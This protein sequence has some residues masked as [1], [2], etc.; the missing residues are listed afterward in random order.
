VAAARSARYS[1][2]TTRDEEDDAAA[3]EAKRVKAMESTLALQERMI[4]TLENDNKRLVADNKKLRDAVKAAANSSGRFDP[5]PAAASTTPDPV[6]PKIKAGIAG[7][8]DDRAAVSPWHVEPG[9]HQ[10]MVPKAVMDAEI[11]RRTRE[12]D[13]E[14][15]DMARKVAWYVDHQEFNRA[16]ET[17]IAEQQATIH[18]LRAKLMEMELIVGRPAGGPSKTDKDRQIRLLQ[19]RVVELEEAHRS[20]QGAHSLT[21]LI[22]ACRPPVNEQR[23]YKALEG[24]LQEAEVK[25]REQEGQAQLVIDRLRVESDNLRVQ[26]QGK[27]ERVEEELRKRLVETQT[28]KVKELEK[29]LAE[30]RKNF[31]ERV[32]ALEHANLNLRRGVP[33]AAPPP[34]PRGRPPSHNASREDAEMGEGLNRSR[35]ASP[36]DRQQNV[37]PPMVP[38]RVEHDVEFAP[39]DREELHGLQRLRR[40]LETENEDLR[41]QVTSLRGEL[42]RVLAKGRPDGASADIAASL[43]MQLSHH[44][45][46]LALHR[47]LLKE[48]QDN[49]RAAHQQAEDRV[50]QVRVASQRELEDM[51]YRHDA[52]I[53]K[54]RE[55]HA[56]EVQAIRKCA[57]ASNHEADLRKLLA[58]RPDMSRQTARGYLLAVAERLDV[59]ERREQA[60]E[61]EHRHII[62][63]AR[64]VAESELEIEKQRFDLALRRKNQEIAEFQLQLD[65][66]LAE[67]ATLAPPGSSPGRKG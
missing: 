46:E 32:K 34:G 61:A 64:R 65:Y 25:L 41:D 35:S 60:R 56:A 19:Q 23:A 17:L 30:A 43:Q 16:Q 39:G 7:D 15:R 42:S 3:K 57:E 21:E 37:V 67:L 45:S 18:D 63:E 58:A 59:L 28:R 12:H 1:A 62:E 6:K 54:L 20:T 26:Y 31:S 50:Y 11:D 44:E 40:R 5:S 52:T 49:V 48:A 22:R 29:A 13:A 38:R 2:N 36:G 4:T 47:R 10:P 66:L 53:K 33:S 24:K 55:E 51:R 14:L 27:L 8:G 9:A